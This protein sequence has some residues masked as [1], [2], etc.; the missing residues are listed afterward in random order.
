MVV[1]KEY[2]LEQSAAVEMVLLS[3][4]TLGDLE[5]G[6]QSHNLHR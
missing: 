5:L 3:A 1:S 4:E 6:K 2:C